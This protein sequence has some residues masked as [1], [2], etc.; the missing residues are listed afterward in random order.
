MPS[1]RRIF[2]ASLTGSGPGAA[3]IDALDA[4]AVGITE[5]KVN[6]V[7]DADVSDFLKSHSYCLLG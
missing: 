5:R 3:R 4:L 6:W 7:L 1:T 2:S